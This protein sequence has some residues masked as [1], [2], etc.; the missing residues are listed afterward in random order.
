VNRYL[1]I[2]ALCC[3]PLF[4]SSYPDRLPIF[5][6]DQNIF[7]YAQVLE[8]ATEDLWLDL[9]ANIASQ[10]E[11]DFHTEGLALGI[12][13]CWRGGSLG[14][15]AFY[16]RDHFHED[17]HRDRGRI[18]SIGIGP[19][20]RM[21][22]CR[23]FAEAE[24]IYVYNR[25]K[26]NRHL[27]SHTARSNYN[28]DQLMPHLKFAYDL[29]YFEPFLTLDWAINWVSAVDEMGTSGRYFCSTF[30]SMLRT[31]VG[32]R[33]SHCRQLCNGTLV[34]SAM[35]SYV[36]K[37]PF[38]L[39]SFHCQNLGS[40]GLSLLYKNRCGYSAMIAYDGEAGDGYLSNLVELKFGMEF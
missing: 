1:F 23:L 29:C 17:H 32:L 25:I 4:G 16:S 3:S 35:A 38:E 18:V 40:W 34:L 2:I 6:T 5:I 26:N 19:Y 15:A 8:H 36:N 24:L 31:A 27:H 7:T 21:Q 12:Q 20:F 33:A 10:N 22:V 30:S 28:T 39:A 13:R 37:A 9:F 14:L 11:I